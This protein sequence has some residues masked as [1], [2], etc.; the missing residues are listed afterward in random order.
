MRILI[1]DDEPLARSRL[2]ALLRDLPGCEV[3]GEAGNGIQAL[4]Q[5]QALEP[6]VVLLDIRMP[7]MDGIEAARH[8]STLETPPAVI[9]TT[10]Y[11]D[12]ALAAFETC[13]LDYL[14]KPIRQ[15]R[16]ARALENCHRLTRAQLATL[17]QAGARDGATVQPEARSHISAR[18]KG[19][20]RLVPV[21]DICFFHADQ[22]YVT[23]GYLDG[24]VLIDESLKSLEKEFGDR[25]VRIHRNAL[26][27][28]A[29]IMGLEKD[30]E[31]R[32]RIILRDCARRLEISRRHLPD[33]R[34]QLR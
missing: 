17:Q 2:A 4:E 26:V 12:Y 34:R 28:R 1:V 23:V 8:L 7:G 18:V 25:F 29:R 9:F 5:V 20:L 22:K 6:D 13:A 24:E 33:I 3:A 27:A 16:L 21:E 10:A 14:L 15:E 31:G 32:C 11:D 30:R 19:G